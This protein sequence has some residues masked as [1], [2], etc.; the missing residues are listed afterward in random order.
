MHTE[1]QL[2]ISWHEGAL[3]NKVTSV[4]EW[5]NEEKKYL[6]KDTEWYLTKKRAAQWKKESAHQHTHTH[7]IIKWK[8]WIGRKK[9]EIDYSIWFSKWARMKWKI[10]QVQYFCTRL[11][12]LEH[13]S[14]RR[15]KKMK[16][17][18]S[19]M[20]HSILHTIL[21][22]MLFHYYRYFQL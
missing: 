6:T 12:E 18:Y 20:P 16:W 15:K 19:W 1:H 7:I 2:S 17:N 22:N 5:E 11:V 9:Q 3:M 8:W 21:F 13:C 4:C 10:A 14:G